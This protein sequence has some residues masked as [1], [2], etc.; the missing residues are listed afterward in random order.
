M[1]F[2]KYQ[3]DSNRKKHGIDFFQ[4][5]VLWEGPERLEVPAG[6][7]KEKRFIL[8]GKINQK[9]WSAVFTLRNNKTRIISVGRSRSQEVTAFES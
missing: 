1:E 5:Q 3:N 8:I 4:A 7:E 2:D 6:T 9:H